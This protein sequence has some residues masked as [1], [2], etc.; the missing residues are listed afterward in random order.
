MNAVGLSCLQAK[1]VRRRKEDL[2]ASL[3]V[4]RI[5]EDCTVGA[6]DLLHMVDSSHFCATF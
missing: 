5:I 1:E 2:S 3:L 4:R 6:E